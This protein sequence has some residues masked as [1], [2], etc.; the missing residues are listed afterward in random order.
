MNNKDAPFG[1]RR[2]GRRGEEPD[3]ARDCI[4]L[5]AE[6]ALIAA[7]IRARARAGL[8]QAEIA[9][10]MGTTQSAIA[11][12]ESGRVT[13]SLHTLRRYAE[14][15]GARVRIVLEPVAIAAPAGRPTGQA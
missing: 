1:S 4:A 10:R 5:E 9:R 8:S 12:L 11:R 6:G 2:S 13:P 15:T 3:A 14:A 7:L